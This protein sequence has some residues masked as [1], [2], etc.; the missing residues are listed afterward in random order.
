MPVH[1]GVGVWSVAAQEEGVAG[2]SS[3]AVAQSA[4]ARTVFQG[5]AL[6]HVALRDTDQG[7]KVEQLEQLEL[8]ELRRLVWKLLWLWTKLQKTSEL[9]WRPVRNKECDCVR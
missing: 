6:A 4:D 1:A 9:L 7:L 3:Q 5:A 8:L 2:C